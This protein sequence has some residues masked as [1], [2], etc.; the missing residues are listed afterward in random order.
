MSYWQ[1]VTPEIIE[2]F[3]KVDKNTINPPYDSLL[4]LMN[5]YSEKVQRM[6]IDMGCSDCRRLIYIFW[7]KT[8]KEW[9]EKN[10]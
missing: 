9:Q 10:N 8:I 4:F 5:T 2:H 1:L 6:R 7:R 3:N